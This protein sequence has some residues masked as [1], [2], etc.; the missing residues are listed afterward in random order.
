MSDK[1]IKEL[2]AGF[3]N[4]MKPID[5]GDLKSFSDGLVSR[6]AARNMPRTIDDGE[7]VIKSR[8]IPYGTTRQ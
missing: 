7:Y 5:F 3:L 2:K 4:S 6:L 8:Y 1:T